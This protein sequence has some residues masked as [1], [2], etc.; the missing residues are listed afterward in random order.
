MK[1][2]VFSAAMLCLVCLWCAAPA[3]ALAASFPSPYRN[4]LVFLTPAQ[5]SATVSVYLYNS[6]QK[7]ATQWHN[8]FI[9]AQGSGTLDLT[10]T[11]PASTSQALVSPV[12]YIWGFSFALGSTLN[13]ISEVLT[14][15]STFTISL[16]PLLSSFIFFN[17][18]MLYEKGQVD[19]PVVLTATASGI[20][21]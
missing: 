15:N 11:L 9:I 18:S 10:V 7:D 12:Y 8:V 21:F 5:S 1:K 14:N 17:V 16:T 3:S 20:L 13:V 19:F 4:D 2:T 6:I